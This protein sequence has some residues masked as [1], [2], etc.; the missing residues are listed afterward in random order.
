MSENDI[1]AIST[2]HICKNCRLQKLHTTLHSLFI[3][4]R[5]VTERVTLTAFILSLHLFPPPPDIHKNILILF[6][7]VDPP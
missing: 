3:S 4:I 5:R 1:S 2:N 7:F 6:G